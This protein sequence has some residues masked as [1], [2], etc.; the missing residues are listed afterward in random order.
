MNITTQ[1]TSLFPKSLHSVNRQRTRRISD[2]E[3][4]Y[5]IRFGTRIKACG[6][7]YYHVLSKDLISM[8]DAAWSSRVHGVTVVVS[9][10][11][12]VLTT[13][14]SPGAYRSLKKRPRWAS[15]VRPAA[16]YAF[17]PSTGNLS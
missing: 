5:A 13:Y 10:D 15:D 4:D 11:G 14:R 1:Q 12:V 16:Q 7:I 9:S 6:V 3:I 2:D 8:L 17:A